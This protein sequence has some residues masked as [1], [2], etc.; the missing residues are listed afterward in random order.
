[1]PSDSKPT[2]RRK[3]RSK[4]DP[5][6]HL[7]GRVSDREVARLAG[8]TPDGVR[9]YRQR[10]AIPAASTRKRGQR[11]KGVQDIQ[12]SGQHG[13]L[14]TVK[15]GTEE[16]EYVVLAE[17]LALAAGQV[18]TALPPAWVLL[19]IRYLAEGL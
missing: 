8:M 16:R 7:L 6:K 10:H 11:A 15:S 1:M 18:T 9:M 5:Y 12:S 3:R 2:K 19:R 17:D 13:F 4:L 14:A